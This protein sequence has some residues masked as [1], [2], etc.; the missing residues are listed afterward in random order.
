[1]VRALNVLVSIGNRTSR[2]AKV[3]NALSSSSAL[4]PR[5]I[6]AARVDVRLEASS[7]RFFCL[8]S[9]R[10]GGPTSVKIPATTQPATTI[11]HS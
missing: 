11:Q 10:S 8:H 1:M 2:S 4:R 6:V 7:T 5:H 9:P 3:P